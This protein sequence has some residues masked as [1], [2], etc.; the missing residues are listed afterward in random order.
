MEKNFQQQN[1]LFNMIKQKIFFAVIIGFIFF[2]CR[3]DKPQSVD[4]TTVSGSGGVLITNEGNFQFGNAKLS[5]YDFQTEN[6]TEDIFQNANNHV[7]GDVLQSINVF[8]NKMYLVLNNS[9]KIVV[10]NSNNIVQTS[11][12]QGFNSPRY[13]LPITNKKAY[14]TD[15]YA[16][17]ISI[18]DLSS[19]TISGSI[20]LHG[21]TEQLIQM[22]GEVFVCNKNSN[23]L[24]VIDAINDVVKDSISIGFAANSIVEDKNGK[25]WILCGGISSQNIFASLHRINPIS[26]QVEKS[27]SFSNLSDAPMRLKFNGSNDTL[28]FISGGIFRMNITDNNLPNTPFIQKGTHNFY[29]LGIRPQ[30]GEVF[31]ADAIDFVQ[32][33]VIYRYDANGNLITTFLAGIIPG[34]FLFQ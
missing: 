20:P 27:F 10:A 11:T 23:K 29:G 34:D 28:Y 3:K 4:N 30:N 14:V 32:R 25:L 9:Q 15:L 21:W 26:H 33:G 17:A 19:N 6:V 13:F 5:Y 18:V 7:L 1:L 22:Y 31:A 24:Y 16:N 8:N 2:S 12:I